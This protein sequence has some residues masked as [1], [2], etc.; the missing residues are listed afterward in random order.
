MGVIGAGDG[1]ADGGQVHQ[2]QE[3]GSVGPGVSF[4]LTASAQF[5]H[6]AQ[7]KAGQDAQD[8]VISQ[9]TALYKAFCGVYGSG[10]GE[11]RVNL[12]ALQMA[13]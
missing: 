10:R 2:H 1:E 5:G 13:L 4:Q 11:G 12:E 6:M 7:V 8:V 3:P 9:E